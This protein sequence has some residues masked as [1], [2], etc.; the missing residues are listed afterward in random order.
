MG[1]SS[2]ALTMS[3][4]SRP[5]IRANAPGATFQR[6]TPQ[7]LE[8]MHYAITDEFSFGVGMW[9]CVDR[10]GGCTIFELSWPENENS[11]CVRS[12]VGYAHRWYCQV[13]R[14]VKSSARICCSVLLVWCCLVILRHWPAIILM[15]APLAA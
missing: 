13:S 5:A 3:P 12:S 11:S 7:L 8:E 6:M 1:R 2:T 4:T 14:Y 10:V 15:P 9:A